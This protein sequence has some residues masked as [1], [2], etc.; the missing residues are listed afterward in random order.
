MRLCIDCGRPYAYCTS[1]GCPAKSERQPTLGEYVWTVITAV[2]A[3][4]VVVI[5]VLLAS[6]CTP[7]QQQLMGDTSKYTELGLRFAACAQSVLA[8]DERQKLNERHEAARLAEEEANNI[9]EAA[10]EH[11]GSVR[12]EVEKVLKDGAPK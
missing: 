10:R 11:P 2:C 4:L 5:V 3:A 6:S 1:A 7:A 12:D 8:E 9:S